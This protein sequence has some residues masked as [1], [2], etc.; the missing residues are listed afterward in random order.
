MG[1][2]GARVGLPGLFSWLCLGLGRVLLLSARPA[3]AQLPTLQVSLAQRAAGH[4]CRHKCSVWLWW[5]RLPG[6]LE[7]LPQPG[8]QC[9]A[10]LVQQ[11]GKL[12]VVVPVIVLEESAGL[13]REGKLRSW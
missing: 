4:P 2:S 3:R 13:K 5:P 7:V 10:H 6:V 12:D 9:L 1:H 8:G 11:L